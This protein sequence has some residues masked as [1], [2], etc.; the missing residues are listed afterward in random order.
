MRGLR[1]Q[2]AGHAIEG[3]VSD[4]AGKTIAE[5]I[6]SAHAGIDA[7]AGDIVIADVDFVMGQDGTSPL[8]IKALQRMGVT[9]VFDPK[10]VAVVMDH[11]SLIHI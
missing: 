2:A 1:G 7:H 11:L 6:F 3:R 9:E 10:K 4:I 8:A 5:K